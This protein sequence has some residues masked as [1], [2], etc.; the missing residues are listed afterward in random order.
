MRAKHS[1][2]TLQACLTPKPYCSAELL[3]ELSGC[4]IDW[5][6]FQK[7]VQMPKLEQ[8]VGISIAGLDQNSEPAAG[9]N[10]VG[11]EIAEDGDFLATLQGWVFFRVVSKSLG[12]LV[13]RKVHAKQN[14][15]RDDVT[16]Q[17]LS[18]LRVDRRKTTVLLSEDTAASLSSTRVLTLE[19]LQEVAYSILKWEPEDSPHFA[20]HA[21]LP[22]VT[23]L[24]VS[25]T[26]RALFSVNATESHVLALREGADSEEESRQGR[27]LALTPQDSGHLA[28]LKALEQHGSV[29]CVADTGAVATWRLTSEGEGMVSPAWFLVTC[30]SVSAVRDVDFDSMTS[31]E[32][33]QHLKASGWEGRIWTAKGSPPA[34]VVKRVSPKVWWLR[35]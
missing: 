1:W 4:E 9:Q 25:Q 11:P 21:A 10:S 34:V 22:G 26:L 5:H 16:V 20:F 27:G 13:R 30:S 6:E 18:I 12:H 35:C 14:L 7:H 29:C 23:K 24:Q 8:D 3:S 33:F 17:V 28:V 31:W 2:H 15:G 19:E 32:L